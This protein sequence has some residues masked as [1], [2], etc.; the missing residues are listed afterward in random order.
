MAVR[1]MGFTAGGLLAI[2]VV[3][4]LATRPRTAQAAGPAVGD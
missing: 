1:G 2:G 4:Y 3:L